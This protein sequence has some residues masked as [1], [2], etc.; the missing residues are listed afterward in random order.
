MASKDMNLGMASQEYKMT[1]DYFADNVFGAKIYID[2]LRRY[3]LRVEDHE[4]E[5]V[6]RSLVN[7]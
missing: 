7:A 4:I 1:I 5:F 3:I 2:L 6:K